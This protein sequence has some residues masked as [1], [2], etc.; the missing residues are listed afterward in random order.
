MTKP[1][2]IRTFWSY[3]SVR[4]QRKIFLTDTHPPLFILFPQKASS[5]FF[6]IITFDGLVV[7]VIVQPPKVHIAESGR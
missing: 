7:V 5:G 1:I 4:E 3:L 6:R 2:R